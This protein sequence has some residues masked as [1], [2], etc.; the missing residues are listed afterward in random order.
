MNGGGY[1]CRGPWF[2]AGLRFRQPHGNTSQDLRVVDIGIIK[3]RGIYKDNATGGLVGVEEGE[4]FDP[5]G[6]RPQVMAN[7]C[8]VFAN[9]CVNELARSELMKGIR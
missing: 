6:M 3:A 5:C 4:V 7:G 2:N 8:S 1:Y 9:D